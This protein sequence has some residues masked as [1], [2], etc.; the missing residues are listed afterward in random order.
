M[1]LLR[2]GWLEYLQDAEQSS[3]LEKEL[4]VC[5]LF[6]NQHVKEMGS[7]SQQ[8]PKKRNQ[9]GSSLGS[10]RS[11]RLEGGTVFWSPEAGGEVNVIVCRR[12]GSNPEQQE[13][14]LSWEVHP[15]RNGADLQQVR[16]MAGIRV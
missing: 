13:Q 5:K 7:V 2:T 16:Q 4:S 14:E 8:G 15:S 10:N 12:V 11:L 3:I 6:S 1:E 9:V